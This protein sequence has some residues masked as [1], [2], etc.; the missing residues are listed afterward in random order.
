MTECDVLDM[1]EDFARDMGADDTFEHVMNLRGEIFRDVPGRR[2]LRFASGGKSYF[3]KM[4]YG[5]GWRETLKNLA[6][7]RLPIWGAATEWRAIHRLRQLGVPTTPPVAFGQRGCMPTSQRS[8]IITED[9]GNILSLEDFC[10]NWASQPPP[11]SLKRRLLN[12]VADI[13]RTLH[14]NGLCH[15]DL[16]L[17]HFCLDTQ[18][19]AQG[20]ISL[21]LLDLHRMGISRSISGSARCKDMAALYFSSLDYGLSQRDLLR[22]LR[23]YRGRPLRALVTQEAKFWQKVSLRAAK[24]YIKYQERYAAPQA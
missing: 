8:F 19:L 21:Y 12:A 22:F 7:L 16:Y 2:T 11:I 13:A 18:R 24:L 1:P 15:R 6:S 20:Q 4:H 5:V 23:R 9:L 3:A 17:C 10:R 14:E